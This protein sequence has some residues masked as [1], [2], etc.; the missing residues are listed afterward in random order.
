MDKAVKKKTEGPASAAEQ[1]TV[2]LHK[3]S[4]PE[5]GASRSS[6]PMI[7]SPLGSGTVVGVL[8][9]G[10]GAL[11]YEILHRELQIK[12]AVKLLR[13]NYTP[14]GLEL[15]KREIIITAQLSHPN[16]IMIHGAGNYNGRPYIEM[17]R[18]N[19]RT[20]ATILKEKGSIAVP[21]ALAVA[22]Y[23]CK[24]LGYAHNRSYYF[25]GKECS[26]RS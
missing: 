10:G 19:G 21:A 7:G 1:E 20:L 25:D 5:N 14:I 8:G 9:G 23:I 3:P 4:E 2:G 16:I 6:D 13:P 18:V 26:R 11:V 17:E 24:A 15:F 22:Y 12:R